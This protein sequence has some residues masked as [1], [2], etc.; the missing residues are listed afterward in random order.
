VRKSAVVG[1][2]FSKILRDKGI[3][4]RPLAVAASRAA[5]AGAGPA[6]GDVDGGQKTQRR[7]TTFG[8][9]GED[10]D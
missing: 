6:A 1:V 9:K 2:G 7:M 4:G 5:I 10:C 8:T 3:D